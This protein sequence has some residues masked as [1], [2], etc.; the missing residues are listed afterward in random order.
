[1][2]EASDLHSDGVDRQAMLVAVAGNVMVKTD[3]FDDD[4]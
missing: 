4:G 1:M 2:S 3:H